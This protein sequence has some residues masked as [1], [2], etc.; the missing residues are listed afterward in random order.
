MENNFF[1]I[2]IYKNIKIARTYIKSKRLK[3]T[4]K[5]SRLIKNSIE[6]LTHSFTRE[7]FYIKALKKASANIKINLKF[8]IKLIKNG[9]YIA[10]YIPFIK[11]QTKALIYN[12]F[13]TS[14]GLRSNGYL[15]LILVDKKF[16]IMF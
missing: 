5:V 3:F 9:H 10:S 11:G 2:N 6:I 1:N 15:L 4:L 7:F 14:Y 12:Y 8:L 13:S 16:N